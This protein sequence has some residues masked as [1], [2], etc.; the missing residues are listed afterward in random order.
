MNELPEW[1]HHTIVLNDA[2]QVM[3]FPFLSQ[4]AKE[5]R[6]RRDVDRS[7]KLRQSTQW[8]IFVYCESV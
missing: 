1:Q 4:L 7:A 8:W 5:A 2:E 3:I 6:T